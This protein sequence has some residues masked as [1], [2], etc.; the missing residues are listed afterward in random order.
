MSNGN[1]RVLGCLNESDTYRKTIPP[2]EEISSKRNTSLNLII[3]N[4]F[5]QPS[6]SQKDKIKRNLFYI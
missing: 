4:Q 1:Q 6:T 5:T 2:V 3:A